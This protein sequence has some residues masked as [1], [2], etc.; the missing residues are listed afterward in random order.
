MDNIT[1]PKDADIQGT[2]N[3]LEKAKIQKTYWRQEEEKT[4][5]ELAQI[6]SNINQYKGWI[7]CELDI[8]SIIKA[9]KLSMYT[10]DELT[11][12]NA[13]DANRKIDSL[14]DEIKDHQNKINAVRDQFNYCFE[15]RV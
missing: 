7:K 8:A 15:N 13:E 1:S 2:E 14:G 4:Q 6:C 3:N 10:D 12:F 5:N 11:Q 9:G